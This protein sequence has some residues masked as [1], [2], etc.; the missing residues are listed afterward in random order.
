MNET[1]YTITRDGD[2]YVV[3]V[4][5]LWLASADTVQEAAKEVEEYLDSLS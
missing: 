5:G 2:H 1:E 3:Y 4:N